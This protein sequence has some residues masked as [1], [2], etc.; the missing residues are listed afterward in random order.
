VV[1]FR[2][3]PEK[4]NQVL[5]FSTLDST[6]PE[7]LWKYLAGY[8]QKTGGGAF[9]IPR[10]GNV[11]N[12]LMFAMSDFVGNPLTKDYA[13][14]RARWEP[15][16]EVT[17]TKGDSE[18]HPLLSPTDEFANFERWDV[19]NLAN[20]VDPKKPEMLQYEYARSA[21]KEGLKHEASLG[22]NP[23]KF[24]MIGSTDTHTG[25]SSF[26]EDNFMGKFEMHPPGPNRWNQVFNKFADGSTAI[27]DWQMQAAGIAG[28]W[29]HE[30]T[31]EALFDAMKRKEVYASTGPRMTVRVFAGWD[32]QKDEVERPDFV[33]RGYARGVPM[34]GDLSKAPAGKSPTFL[35]SAVRDPDGGNLYRVQI[36]KGWIDAKGEVH[37]H[38][39]DVAVSGKR[40]I[41]RDGRSKTPVGNTVDV[42]DASYTNTIG[43]PQLNTWWKDPT[44]DAKQGAFYYVRVIQIPTP[45]W[46]AYEQKRFGIK[47]SKEVPVIVAERAYTSPIW[48]SPSS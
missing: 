6:D 45:R 42:A 7:D 3:G 35:I 16:V 37:E 32:F 34:G 31:R 17:Q 43:A 9:A 2:D 48:Y 40:K 8:E 10:N 1:I 23:F 27:T 28:V 33:A 29:A 15:L 38:I 36:I 18:A 5:P 46:T 22:T 30:N 26:D 13:E 25:M 21:L 44:F 41:G 47:M 39:F 11:S 19:G 4:V 24:G 14:R 12:G 20:P